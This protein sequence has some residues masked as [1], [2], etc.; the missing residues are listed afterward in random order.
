[1]YLKLGITLTRSHLNEWYGN[2]TN[3]ANQ[4]ELDLSNRNIS[5]IQPNTFF[6]LRKVVKIDLYKNQ[7]SSLP[8]TIFANSTNQLKFL[9][10]ASNQ[11]VTLPFDLFK[12]LTQLESLILDSNRL[13][14]LPEAIFHGLESL[15]EI[16]LDNNELYQLPENLFLNL[17]KVK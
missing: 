9:R 13:S 3:L 10:L 8:S 16:R 1:M 4:T 2:A 5:L 7:M 14:L 15:K 11:F 17:N 6:D 12:G